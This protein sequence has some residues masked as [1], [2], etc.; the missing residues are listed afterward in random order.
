MHIVII[1]SWYSSEE[2]I[3]L[4]SFF[5][6]QALAL[7]DAG[8]EVTICYNENFPIYD[9]KNLKYTIGKSIFFNKEDNLDTYRYRGVNYLLHNHRRF[10]MFANRINRLLDRVISDKGKIDV[11]HFHSCYW[12][13]VCAPYVKD[14]FN[15]PYVLTEHT[16]ITYS[17][18]IKKSYMRYI[19]SAYDHADKL[20]SVSNFLKEEM[21]RVS[22]NSIEVLPNFLDGEKFRIIGEY[23]NNDCSKIVFFSLAFLVEGKGFRELIDACKILVD[24]GYD[25][26]L[27]IGGDG[28]LREDLHKK[29]E[30]YNLSKYI[31]F[32][33]IL[34]RDEV[35]RTMNRC[36]VFVL[37]SSYE[38]FGVVYIEA[39]ACGKPVIGIK[40]GGAEE[41]IKED[42]GIILDNN[43]KES[44]AHAMEE[45]ILNYDRYNKETIRE[46]FVK[47][48]EKSII[49]DRLKDVY[50]TCLKS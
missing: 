17:N 5:K 21:S 48:F 43:K 45:M 37:A 24:K 32:L 42:N 31:K 14:K 16:G 49:I 12:A 7:Q 13:G 27:E 19:R 38:T 44:I 40:N 15:I 41:I 34:T 9:Y 39:L 10:R 47:N 2:N 23:K 30:R 29:V 22:N 20:L 35:I 18:R 28:Y 36:D 33:G 3:V 25:F 6:E 26:I 11:L 46:Y 1:P 8:E 50:R 4:G